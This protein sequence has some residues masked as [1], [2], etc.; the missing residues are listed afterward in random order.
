MEWEYILA[1]VI[2]VPFI[3]LPVGF[4]WFVNLSGVRH[5][6]REVLKARVERVPGVAIRG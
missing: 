1:L 4:I 5:A 3:L 2:T 6:V